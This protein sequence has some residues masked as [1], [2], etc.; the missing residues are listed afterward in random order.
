MNQPNF[1]D[2]RNKFKNLVSEID[3]AEKR[4]GSHPKLDALREDARKNV[5]DLDEGERNW[6]AL[7]SSIDEERE[8]HREDA[9]AITRGHCEE[10]QTIMQKAGGG[11]ELQ[12]LAL[13]ALT[14][15]ADPVGR[16]KDL[17]LDHLQSRPTSQRIESGLQSKSDDIDQLQNQLKDT[18]DPVEKK[19]LASTISK[20]RDAE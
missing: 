2:L 19:Q 1:A 14:H 4:H 16:F 12:G 17:V 11:R 8:K 9:F 5:T 15:H 7:E 13:K 20:L 3:E 18:T 10:I 6:Q